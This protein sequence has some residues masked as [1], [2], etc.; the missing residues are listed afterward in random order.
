VTSAGQVAGLRIITG[1]NAFFTSAFEMV[2]T[3]FVI[4]LRYSLM[5]ISLSQKTDD[6][7]DIKRR[8]LCSYSITDE[9]F[10]L[11]STRS[12]LISVPFFLGLSILP[13][14]GWTLGTATGALVSSNIPIELS[15]VFGIA[16]Y[17]MFLSIFV[18]PAKK[19]K[20]TLLCVLTAG[21]I[22]CLIYYCP[23]LK[24]ISSGFS[25]IVSSVIASIITSLIYPHS[26]TNV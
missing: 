9:I 8:M 14:V 3:Q 23:I 1:S 22:S 18:P 12:G 6:S 16:I 19:D 11:A 26:E 10:A 25:I 7:F 17:G 4:N 2:L 5:G 13:I 21:L 24:F 20:G 15:A